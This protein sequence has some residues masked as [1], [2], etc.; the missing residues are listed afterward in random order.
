LDDVQ[1]YAKYLELNKRTISKNEV[2]IRI[3]TWRGKHYFGFDLD[4]WLVEVTNI[5]HKEKEKLLNVDL[6]EQLI[7]NLCLI[8]KGHLFR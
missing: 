3:S 1:S 5:L 4:D 8:E 6:T 2:I 7:A